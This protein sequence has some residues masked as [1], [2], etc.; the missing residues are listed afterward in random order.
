MIDS[1]W[2]KTHRLGYAAKAGAWFVFRKFLEKVG[3]K[4]AIPPIP[5]ST[6]HRVA[7]VVAC[8]QGKALSP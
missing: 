8:D 7:A 3:E 1:K 6:T 5:S 4:L 2:A